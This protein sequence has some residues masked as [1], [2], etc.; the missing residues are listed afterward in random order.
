MVLLELHYLPCVA[1]FSSFFNDEEILLETHEN[2]GKQSYRNRC[3]I[4]SANKVDSLTVPVLGGNKKIGIR[5]I[6]IDYSQGWVKDHWRA[7]QSAYG[8]SPYFEYYADYIHDVFKRKHK[9]LFDLNLEMLTLCLGFLQMDTKIN[10]TKAYETSY[11]ESIK[12]FRG[13]LTPKNKSEEF[14]FFVINEY[15]QIFGKDFV[16]NL[17]IVD[18]LFCEGPNARVIIKRSGIRYK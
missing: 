18:L 2:Y 12:D 7:L 13:V 3:R 6:G 1:Y 8:R 17:S 15:P 5:D 10:F 16:V 9:F 11:P 14:P 4:K